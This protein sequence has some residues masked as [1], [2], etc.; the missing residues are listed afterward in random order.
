LG[1]RLAAA[2]ITVAVGGIVIF[3]VLTVTAAQRQITSLVHETHRDD[4]AAAAAAA[5]AA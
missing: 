5:A 1:L 3:A 4:A 2:F